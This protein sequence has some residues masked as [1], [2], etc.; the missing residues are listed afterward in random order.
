MFRCVQA[1]MLA[2]AVASSASAQAPRSFPANALRG[3]IVI[4]QPPVVELNGAPARLA[5]GARIRGRD[6]LLQM[7]GAL[8]GV[9]LLVHYTFSTEGLV[10]DVWILTDEERAKAP[11]PVTPAQAR[12]WLFDPDAQTWTR[13]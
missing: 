2:V 3:E 4:A 8:V 6:N 5:P 7:S 13:R 10:Q 1:L 9:P 11:W 12:T